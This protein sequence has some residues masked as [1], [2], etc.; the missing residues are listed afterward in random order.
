MKII[1]LKFFSAVLAALMGC[2]IVAT[3]KSFD[4]GKLDAKAEDVAAV[5]VLVN[6]DQY[7]GKKVRVIGAYFHDFEN[8]YLFLSRDALEA[9][10][11]SSAL[12]LPIQEKSLPAAADDLESL[13]GCLVAVEG[14]VF[15]DGVHLGLKDV[16]RIFLKG[17]GPTNSIEVKQK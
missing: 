9:Y 14:I 11:V 16:S 1:S 6:P 5:C 13:N 2:G 17:R 15:R 8:S 10:D 7:V 4:F 3:A 12:G